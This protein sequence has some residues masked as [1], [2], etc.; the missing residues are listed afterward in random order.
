MRG[1]PLCFD[2]RVDARQ[3]P[4]PD[5]CNKETKMMK[6]PA[7][8]PVSNLDKV[9]FKDWLLALIGLAFTLAGLFILTRDTRT[10]ITT[11]VVFGPC[12]GLAA[13]RI[14]R[15][16]RGQRQIVQSASVAGGVPI[17]F[18]RTRYTLMGLGMLAGGIVLALFLPEKNL[19]MLGCAWFVA[20]TGAVLLVG[21]ATG[22][23]AKATI[24]FDPPGITFGFRQGKA[25]VPWSA[26][27]GISR[28][29]IHNNPTVFIGVNRAA[30][31]AEPSAYLGTVHKKMASSQSWL[32]ADFVIMTS[33]YGLDAV[34]LCAA[35]ERYASDPDARAELRAR[36]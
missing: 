2:I 33:T 10:G 15:K 9:S 8:T 7:A 16:L 36:L 27:I 3:S 25:I 12:F 24:Q 34:V 26:I 4:V 18:S 13:H 11:L 20:T 19:V 5:T 28:G 32:G 22:L 1:R 31:T 14:V 17:R 6:T 23:L 30:V 29:E 21:L 35:L